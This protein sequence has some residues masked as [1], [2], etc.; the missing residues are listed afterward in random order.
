[1]ADWHDADFNNDGV[2]DIVDTGIIAY[3][4]GNNNCSL[5]NGT[6]NGWCEGT[7]MNKDGVVDIADVGMFSGY[8]GCNE[9]STNE[10][11]CQQ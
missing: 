2:V 9:N 4:Y 5:N 7:D 6:A 11:G 1:M 10:S 8:Y 3:W